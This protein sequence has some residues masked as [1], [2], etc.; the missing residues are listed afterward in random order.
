MPQIQTT[1]HKKGSTPSAISITRQFQRSRIQPDNGEEIIKATGRAREKHAFARARSVFGNQCDR[2]IS[3]AGYIPLWA[4]PRKKRIAHSSRHVRDI[5]Q[6]M[7]KK[8]QA[9]SSVVTNHLALHR[10]AIYPPG[11]C[12]MI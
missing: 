10:S 7:L 2:R 1:S 9:R 4:S 12:K 8:P 5:P 3:V 6:S 11:T